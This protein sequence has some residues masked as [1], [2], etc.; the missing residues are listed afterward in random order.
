MVDAVTI[1]S[2][3]L[4]PYCS[5]RSRFTTTSAGKNNS[6]LRGVI[7]CLS[8]SPAGRQTRDGESSAR[9]NLIK[10]NIILTCFE[11]PLTTMFELYNVN[12][13]GIRMR[14]EL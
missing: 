14:A 11:E 13:V 1:Q 5:S 8:A 6:S 10:R 9:L 3:Y 2:H 4:S 7:G 12:C